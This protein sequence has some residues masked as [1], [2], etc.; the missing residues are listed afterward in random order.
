VRDDLLA[1]DDPILEGFYSQDP[2][3]GQDPYNESM[4][5]LAT[6]GEDESID[7]GLKEDS[8]VISAPQSH[9]NDGSHSPHIT[10]APAATAP[11]ES[12]AA[13]DGQSARS[14]SMICGSNDPSR[15]QQVAE[16]AD[17]KQE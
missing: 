12:V 2:Y 4:K 11:Q 14:A 9:E 10:T 15:P 5:L 16:V 13:I 7:S 6:A 1:V 3:G 17:G 8:H